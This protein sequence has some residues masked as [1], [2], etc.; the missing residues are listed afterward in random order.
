MTVDEAF[1]DYGIR[2]DQ[3]RMIFMCCHATLSPENRVTLILKTL[4]GF[5]VPPSRARCSPRKP[6]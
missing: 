3:L 5:S 6:R 4:C 2:D 1:S